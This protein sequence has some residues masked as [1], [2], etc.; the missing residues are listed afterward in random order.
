MAASIARIP[1]L[2]ELG[3]VD[4][5]LQILYKLASAGIAGKTAT[6][7]FI[8]PGS[9]ICWFPKESDGFVVASSPVAAIQLK[10]KDQSTS[11]R[12]EFSRPTRYTARGGN[13]QISSL[14]VEG[15]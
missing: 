12:G 10:P 7:A 4:Q 2:I 14:Y 3:S 6:A 13:S 1:I 5:A 9:E 15:Q 11:F 8:A